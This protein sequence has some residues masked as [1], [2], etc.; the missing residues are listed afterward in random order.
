[1]AKTKER[2]ELPKTHQ[3]ET[4][5]WATLEAKTV[6]E[7]ASRILHAVDL[8]RLPPS[9]RALAMTVIEDTDDFLNRYYGSTPTS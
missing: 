3:L 2:V 4:L 6:I 5:G 9:E 1:M 7:N 8:S